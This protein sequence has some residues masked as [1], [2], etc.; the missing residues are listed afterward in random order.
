MLENSEKNITK[1]NQFKHQHS[2]KFTIFKAANEAKIPINILASLILCGSMDDQITE[3]RNKT[4]LESCLWH[5]L[6]EKEQKYA[7]E[8]GP[9]S[10]FKLI[11]IMNKLKIHK[12]EKGKV[13]LKE[14]R[15]NTIRK[16]YE[17]YWELYKHNK[18]NE[19]LSNYYHEK[20]LL[21]FSYSEKLIDLFQKE[22]GRDLVPISEVL[23]DIEDE[24]CHFV[25][26][27]V[28][29]KT[30]LSKEKKTPYLR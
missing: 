26:E 18:K 7:L 8:L 25:A 22:C 29:V 12:D 30:G 15:A 21:G 9:A 23:G 28:E 11:D 16:H 10:N 4:F 27:V 20:R 2:N 14:S 6:S 19:R 1:L 3:T 24:H 5:L 13:V 17:P